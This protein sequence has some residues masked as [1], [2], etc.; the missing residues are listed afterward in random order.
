M[1]VLHLDTGRS[2]RGGQHQVLQLLRALPVESTLLAPA[3]SPLLEH[4]RLLRIPAGP[5]NWRAVR[6]ES[7]EFDLVHCHTGG[8]HTL[9]ALW[10]QG[11][12]V[13]SRR[14]AFPVGR[15]PLSRWKYSRAAH[16]LAVS[17]AVRNELLAAGV[18]PERISVV[19]DAVP[20]PAVV[21]TR[22]GPVVAIG[23]AREDERKGA[24]LLP[25]IGLDLHYSENLAADLLT[26]RALVYVTESEGLGS[27]VLL[28]MAH[29]VPVVAS[30]VGGLTE[31][32]EDGVTGLLVTNDPDSIGTA[33][34]RLLEDE[35]LA[36]RLAAAGR[37]AVKSRFTMERMVEGTLAVY[38]KVLE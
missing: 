19:G 26:A 6:K 9:A 22:E 28:A 8:A 10:S 35:A 23:L 5:L 16:Y 12:F 3:G 24:G 33:V 4:A 32:I 37:S 21:S 27:A 15:G 13:V 11:P 7:R 38:R 18:K 36:D 30:R 14:V 20:Q 34:R 31:L 1:H 25:H 17:G 29:G 2:L